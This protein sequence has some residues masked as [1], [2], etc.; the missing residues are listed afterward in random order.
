MASLPVVR[1]FLL[2]RDLVVA[3]MRQSCCALFICA[4]S[5]N[6]SFWFSGTVLCTDDTEYS[7]VL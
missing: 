6:F 7:T 4:M 1:T 2:I 3:A 5:R